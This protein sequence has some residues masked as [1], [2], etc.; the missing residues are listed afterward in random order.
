M[1]LN[2]NI[3]SRQRKKRP[4]P[5]D[6]FGLVIHSTKG[7]LFEQRPAKGILA[8]FWMFPLIDQQEL[9]N[10][11]P[12]S[13]QVLIQRLQDKL[14]ADYQLQVSLSEIDHQPVSHTFTHQKWQI[15]LLSGELPADSDLSFSL[16]N[17][18]QLLILKR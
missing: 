7:Y 11:Q 16:A 10:D 1:G 2:P 13:K 17:G 4:I 9:I 18:F 8:G 6:Y 5:V 15:T 12:T 14:A 3:L